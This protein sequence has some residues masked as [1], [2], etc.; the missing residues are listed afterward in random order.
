MKRLKV[1]AVLAF[2]SL[3]TMNSFAQSDSKLVKQADD[4]YD[5]SAKESA[6][7]IY[8]MALEEN[9]ANVKA[10]F[11]VG[12][13]YF[14]TIHKPRGLKYF[15]KAFEL[16][17]QYNPSI[18][19]ND[20]PLAE[21]EYKLS[22]LYYIGQAYHF[23]HDFDNAI[24][25]YDRYEGELK[26]MYAS[27]KITS[28]MMDT[29]IE[30]IKRKHYECENG[31]EFVANPKDVVIENIGEQINGPYSDYTPVVS[32]DDKVLIF[33]SR[34]PGGMTEDVADDNVYFEDIYI[35]RRENPE[36]NWS[37]A[38]NIGP[39]VNEE[40]HDA[41]SSIS[42]DGK[43]LFL[44]K[45]AKGGSL[46]SS[47]WE[48]E[49]SGEWGTPKLVKELKSKSSF[50]PHV[51]ITENEDAMYFISNREGGIGENDIW[52]VKKEDEKW[53]DPLNVGEI[54]NTKY[55][56]RGVYVDADGK[57]LYFSS[58]GHKG[59]G[60]LDVFKSEFDEEKK[61]WKE[62]ENVGY[63][64]N[65]SD[66]DV[67]I[68]FINNGEKAYYSSA[69]D[70]GYGKQDIYLV[71]LPIEPEPI[72]EDTPVVAV[73]D[74]P[75]VVAKETKMYPVILKGFITDASTGEPLSVELEIRSSIDNSVITV[76][77]TGLDGA[78][79]YSFT[80]SKEL[81]YTVNAQKTGFIYAS[82]DAVIPAQ[83]TIAQEVV[84]DL[85]LAK[86][87]VGTKVIIR[88]IYYH[89]D[90]YSLKSESYAE[91]DKIEKLMRE[92]PTMKLEISG[93]TDKIGT[94]AY[95]V[96]LSKRRANSVVKFLVNKGIENGRLISAG[97]GESKPLVS[98]DDETDGREINRRTEFIILEK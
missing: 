93:H 53:G 87:V 82:K 69:K 79:S 94:H 47:K 63:P 12:V 54:L 33:T 36:D 92:N 59:M 35:S 76:V 10:N 20:F 38:V 67:F 46:Y 72:V 19:I 22:L 57:T 39:V 74:T 73:V 2:L 95:N 91:L 34:R 32:A 48:E 27:K 5:F 16:D 75:V 17:P 88:N 77:N 64:I 50:E 3:F 29:E 21:P 13:I 66:D 83:D 9:P 30:D 86:A 6:Q 1:I 4:V 24:S 58:E 49:S 28:E 71:T 84:K 26:K 14:E 85:S 31:K 43:T 52:V 90:K 60:G 42:P 96:V 11:M 15:L 89:F 18:L 61:E 80:N 62:P 98:N 41:T 51:S 78:Y 56:E 65:T 68:S 45:D 40:G 25:Y 37:D 55:N 7:Q 97:Y 44:Y 81:T 70:E 8:L 23:S